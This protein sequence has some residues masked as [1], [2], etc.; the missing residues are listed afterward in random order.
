MQQRERRAIDDSGASVSIIEEISSVEVT[1]LEGTSLVRRMS[2]MFANGE[3]LTPDRD[4]WFR[5]VSSGRKYKPVD[6][7]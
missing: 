4:G 7:G 5:S 1:T 3:L 6:Q 2:R